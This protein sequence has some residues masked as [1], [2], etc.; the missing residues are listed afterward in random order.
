MPYAQFIQ[1]LKDRDAR[2]SEVNLERLVANLSKFHQAR[3]ETLINGVADGGAI[4]LDALA[5]KVRE[6][7][8][9]HTKSNL[10]EEGELELFRQ[11]VADW[12][13]LRWKTKADAAR[14]LADEYSAKEAAVKDKIK[15]AL[16]HDSTA[17]AKN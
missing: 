1:A 16:T 15:Q 12:C 8:L 11:F 10:F 17:P 14:A 13:S 5:A 4:N 3:L 2:A 9:H 7:L 6:I